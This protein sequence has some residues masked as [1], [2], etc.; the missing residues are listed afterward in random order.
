MER[1]RRWSPIIL[2][3]LLLSVSVL[4][5]GT[6]PRVAASPH[7]NSDPIEPAGTA[8][9]NLPV[10]Y[11][12]QL[13]DTADSFA[14]RW[15][16]G[17]TSAVMALA[18]YRKIPPQ[19]ITISKPT[20]HTNDYGYYVSSV[21]TAFNYTFN[22]QQNDSAGKAAYGGYG[23]TTDGGMAWAWRIQGYVERH[24]LQHEFDSTPTFDEIKSKL[25]QGYL[26]VLSTDL[27]SAGHIILVRG[28]TNDNKIIVNDPYG[29]KY[30]PNGYG[31]YDGG[32]VQY[33]WSKFK[34]KWMVVVKGQADPDD[35]RILSL[36]QSL[37]GTIAPNNDE[38]LYNFTITAGTSIRLTM[39][40]SG[41]SLDSYLK[42][43]APDGSLV[44]VNDD[45][46]NSQNSKIEFRAP[47]NG[48]YRV[49]AHS[50]NHNSGG[51]YQIA[52][53]SGPTDGDDN[54]W[55]SFGSLLQGTISPNADRDSYFING[56][57]GAYVSLRM[58]RNAGSLDSYLELYSPNGVLVASNDDGGE[59]MNS[60][61]VYRFTS[62]GTYR[63]VARSYNGSSGGAY[64][65]SS[66][67]IRG[68]N[69]ALNRPV[70]VSSTENSSNSSYRG[71]H[72]TDGNRGTRWSSGSSASQFVYVDL[73]QERTINQVVLRWETAYATKYSLYYYSATN[74]RWQTAYTTTS[75]D[76]D[77]DAI[78]VSFRTRY[79]YL[80]MTGR[81]GI[82]RNYS[83][84]ELEAYNTATV[85]AP[86]VPPE[87][88][89]K[90]PEVGYTPLAPLAP[91]PDGKEMPI[92]ALF[93]DQETQP[94]A[95]DNATVDAPT[96]QLSETFGSPTTSITI[97]TATIREG[98]SVTVT[99]VDAHDTD[100][101]QIGSGISAY[102]WALVPTTLGETGASAI[103]FDG[104][105][106]A[107]IPGDLLTAGTYQVTLSVQDDEGGWSDAVTTD[108]QVLNGVYLPLVVR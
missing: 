10:P 42:L 73:G 55:I 11:I 83:L 58:N 1:S 32:N 39:Q 96:T 54:R 24:G 46:D 43:Y 35:N 65:V 44:T 15:A 19:P 37:T 81:S 17:P 101:N 28:Y 90:A 57:S 95:A 40:R 107:V 80:E 70:I 85:L 30:G 50:Y 41:G 20:V 27:T 72:A 69:Y 36:N 93:T 99:A 12:H 103:E 7:Q 105:E 78:N 34:A 56:T 100:S 67:S 53:T 31:K 104:G 52:L 2:I 91:Y 79:I 77:I 108:L 87:D 86:L 18:Y 88:G 48:T 29:N 16:C 3:M 75:G 60:W 63:L 9:V 66:E 62:T 74:N 61:I 98:G 21:Y 5:I 6:L 102:R 64:T 51:T 38:D 59:N 22:R 92:L 84:W 47:T 49:M 82:W 71:S 33:E 68:E 106:T 13:W 76:G 23:H 25:D 26:V 14:G 89:N 97:S 94:L 8:V 45:S 4:W